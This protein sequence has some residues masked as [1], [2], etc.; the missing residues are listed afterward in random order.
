M[1]SS[2]LR[3]PPV[4]SARGRAIA[5][6]DF[7]IA[8][9]EQ[10]IGAP[11]DLLPPEPVRDDKDDVPRVITGRTRPQL[12]YVARVDRGNRGND[13]DPIAKRMSH[14]GVGDASTT[15]PRAGL[16]CPI[17]KSA[18]PTTYIGRS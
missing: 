11:E 6:D 2:D 3:G 13:E 18:T 12:P 17:R 8:E 14:E 4:F 15:V 7:R 10:G 1:C 16:F 5:T 9:E